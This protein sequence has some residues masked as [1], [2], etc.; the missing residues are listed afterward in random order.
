M[1]T[2]IIPLTDIEPTP[3]DLPIKQLAASITSQGLL[4]PV[5]LTGAPPYHI[6]D[7]KRRVAAL[8]SLGETGALALISADPGPSGAWEITLTSN[9]VRSPN[10]AAEAEAIAGLLIDGV[11]EQELAARLHLTVSTIR[12]R[13][14]LL[15]HLTSHFFTELREGRI[16]TNM[17]RRL[18]SC[19]PDVQHDLASDDE[20]LTLETIETQRRQAQLAALDV[21]QIVIPEISMLQEEETPSRPSVPVHE[22]LRTETA[23]MLEE[24]AGEALGNDRQ[25]L[26]AAAKILRR[27]P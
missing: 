1:L 9:L 2:R 8:R 23:E 19:P 25:I 6:L 21:S 16:T 11:T 26:L 10:P 20:P 4:Y 17:A 5:I 12:Q 22:E 18:A 3:P 7:G 15:T 14:R 27:I 13:V 24:F